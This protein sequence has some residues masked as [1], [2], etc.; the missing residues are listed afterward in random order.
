M[1]TLIDNPEFAARFEQLARSRRDPPRH[2]AA[3]A[4]LHALAVAERAVHLG[5]LN[6]LDASELDRLH[7]LGLAHDLG[8]LR[9]APHPEHSVTMLREHG[10]EDSGFLELVRFH[11]IALSWFRSSE[12]GQPPSDKAWRKLA[13][14]VNLRHLCLLMVADRVDCPG[15][16]K[17]NRP[18]L[19]FLAEAR[20]RGLLAEDLVLDEGPVAE[21]APERCA[22]AALVRGASRERQVLL[23]RVRGEQVEL[24]KGH[25]EPGEAPEQAAARELC[26]ETG[27]LK[28]PPCE[29]ALGTL[30]YEVGDIVRR[31]KQVDYF[32]FEEEPAA[33]FGPPPQ[34]TLE[35][36][37]ASAAEL[38]N[39]PLVS[40]P[41]RS[42][43]LRALTGE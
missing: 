35:L 7:D 6:G 22:G 9:G 11:D 36:R 23:I 33:A 39:L 15:G 2:S 3:T 42:L 19:W 25:S 5:R 14:R 16:W 31:R 27:L 26:E 8:K 41:L 37:W 12:R 43:L 28:A 17:A 20:R 1:K 10:I 38:R 30:A 13:A 24:P 32:V 4:R 18:T 34:G 40:E 29:S 21:P